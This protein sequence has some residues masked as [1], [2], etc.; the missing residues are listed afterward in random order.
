MRL[1]IALPPSLL[2]LAPPSSLPPQGHPSPTRLPPL[3][4][5]ICLHPKMSPGPLPASLCSTYRTQREASRLPTASH[6]PWGKLQG[7]SSY[8]PA[9]ANIRYLF[10]GPKSPGLECTL[11][12][13]HSKHLH[14]THEEMGQRGTEVCSRSQDK[15]QEQ[16]EFGPCSLF[17][18]QPPTPRP[19]QVA[20]DNSEMVTHVAGTLLA[21]GDQRPHKS[22]HSL[23]PWH[24][25]A[26]FFFLEWACSS[27]FLLMPQPSA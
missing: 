23:S 18:S 22:R 8:F 14:V 15:K 19:Q 7:N 5:P 26:A 16:P 10:T 20:D 3:C 21:L 6:L 11:L 12:S 24:G 25:G 2:L 17:P 4:L 13:K 9:Q 27:S 1:H